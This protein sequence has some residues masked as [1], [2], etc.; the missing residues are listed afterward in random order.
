MELRM[1]TRIE[2]VKPFLSSGLNCLKPFSHLTMAG[3]SSLRSLHL[4]RP[5]Q[6]PDVSN[7]AGLAAGI[8]PVFEHLPS[9][10]GISEHRRSRALIDV[11][12]VIY[13]IVVDLRRLSLQ[14][15][16]QSQGEILTEP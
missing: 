10:I 15:I 8:V 16:P 12:A 14:Q 3:M 2:S 6:A 11:H 9:N 13:G 1:P 5:L 7:G 4:W